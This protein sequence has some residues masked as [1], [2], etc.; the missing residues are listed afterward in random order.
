MLYLKRKSKPSFSFPYISKTYN[1]SGPSRSGGAASNLTGTFIAHALSTNALQQ[2]IKTQ[3]I[4]SYA[5]RYRTI[6]SAITTHLAPYG[7]DVPLALTPA[8]AGLGHGSVAGGYFIF[9]R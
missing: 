2:H 6:M 7:V 4:P 5:H 8:G 9:L 3:L 1:S